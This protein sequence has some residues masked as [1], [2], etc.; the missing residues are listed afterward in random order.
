M[1]ATGRK[2]HVVMLD[3]VG[4]CWTMKYVS[5]LMLDVL[6]FVSSKQVCQ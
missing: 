3:N 2:I 1:T 4:Q 5:C 6:Y